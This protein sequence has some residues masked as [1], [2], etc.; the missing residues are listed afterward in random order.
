MIN[1]VVPVLDF[2]WYELL[3]KH[4]RIG[5]HGCVDTS[6]KG[7]KWKYVISKFPEV[8]EDD[9][10]PRSLTF[11]YS[12]SIALVYQIVLPVRTLNAA[13]LFRIHAHS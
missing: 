3:L 6:W 2:F 8:E 4:P 12:A 13:T 5:Y 1:F 7:N 11:K 9:K 10:T